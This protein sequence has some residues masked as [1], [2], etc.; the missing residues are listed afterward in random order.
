LITKR[1]VEISK[2]I[3]KMS[4]EYENKEDSVWVKE[5]FTECNQNASENNFLITKA[6]IVFYKE[7]CFPHAARPYDTNLDIKFNYKQLKKYLTAEGR[8]LLLQK[9]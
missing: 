1:K 7:N 4:G 8:R 2:W 6:E 9:N 5:T 3:K